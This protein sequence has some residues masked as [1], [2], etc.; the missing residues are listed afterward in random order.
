MFL[1]CFSK[2][3]VSGGSAWWEFRI[4]HYTYTYASSDGS[5]GYAGYTPLQELIRLSITSHVKSF[6]LLFV[7][8][9]WFCFYDDSLI[10][11]YIFSSQYKIDYPTYLT[12]STCV[13]NV[14]SIFRALIASCSHLSRHCIQMCTCRWICSCVVRCVCL[15]LSLYI[16]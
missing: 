6:K 14:H 4:V 15:C 8:W 5:D 13:M 16:Y 2:I 12:V 3:N 11:F 9:Y 7:F 1:F 10:Y